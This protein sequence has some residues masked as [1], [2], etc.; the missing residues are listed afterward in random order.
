M[1]SRN[2]R[3]GILRGA[4]N[5]IVEY[6]LVAAT[7]ASADTAT[8]G[9]GFTREPDMLGDGIRES[10]TVAA[11]EVVGQMAALPRFHI[12]AGAQAETSQ[13][14]EEFEHFHVTMK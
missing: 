13:A 7:T 9:E 8:A 11:H 14:E 12:G 5:I 6:S 4:L 2:S 1:R 10:I 3:A